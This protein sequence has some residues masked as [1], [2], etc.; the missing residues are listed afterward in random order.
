MRSGELGL[1]HMGSVSAACLVQDG[2]R[3]IGTSINSDETAPVD[4]AL[5][6]VQGVDIVAVADVNNEFRKVP[7][8]VGD[9]DIA[10]DSIGAA[11]PNIHSIGGYGGICR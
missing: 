6:P 4:S 8:M 11:Q 2:N 10:I 9:D 5:S 7:K 1:S 3:V